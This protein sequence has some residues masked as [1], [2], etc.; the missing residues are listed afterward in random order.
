[1]NAGE[2]LMLFMAFLVIGAMVLICVATWFSD[3]GMD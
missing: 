3:D 2:A 1:M